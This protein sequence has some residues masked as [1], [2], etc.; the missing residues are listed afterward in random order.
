MNTISPTTSNAP[1]ASPQDTTVQPNSTQEIDAK[2][3]EFA[4]MM[5]SDAP[6]AESATGMSGEGS[7]ADPQ[8]MSSRS[9]QR[10]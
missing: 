4:A 6:A 7:A 9:D 10:A 5:N 1:T 2:A 8:S 3:D